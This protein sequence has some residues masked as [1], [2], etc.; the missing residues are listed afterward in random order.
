VN[1]FKREP[2]GAGQQALMSAAPDS[3]WKLKPQVPGQ[4]G[5]HGQYMNSSHGGHWN[6]SLG[7]RVF[8]KH[9]SQHVMDFLIDFQPPINAYKKM[10]KYFNL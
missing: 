6:L 5:K 2:S 10:F 3:S 4:P 1:E 9:R 8:F 7:I